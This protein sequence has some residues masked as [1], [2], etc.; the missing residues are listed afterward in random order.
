MRVA[1]GRHNTQQDLPFPEFSLT[2]CLVYSV[3]SD[4]YLPFDDT[5]LSFCFST[6]FFVGIFLFVLETCIALSLCIW[7]LHC[8]Q[9]KCCG[10]VLFPPSLL[11]VC[12]LTL[13]PGINEAKK[14][15]KMLQYV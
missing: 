13:P 14:N 12:V 6:G 7:V 8:Q 15:E 9:G 10:V 2:A 4:C 3:S 11:C 5:V 1:S